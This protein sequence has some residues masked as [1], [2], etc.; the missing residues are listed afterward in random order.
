[1]AAAIKWALVVWST[2]G[3]RV[4]ISMI[5]ERLHERLLWCPVI[6]DM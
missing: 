5:C 6:V 2:R 1:M 3:R 4:E